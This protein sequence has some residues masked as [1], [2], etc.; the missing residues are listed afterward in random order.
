MERSRCE[1]AA[2]A[3]GPGGSWWG[4]WGSNEWAGHWQARLNLNFKL[5]AEQPLTAACQ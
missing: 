5:K 3:S 4:R 1:G 2:S